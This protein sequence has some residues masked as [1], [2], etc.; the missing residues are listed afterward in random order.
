MYCNI[1]AVFLFGAPLPRG[2]VGVMGF[3]STTFV[4]VFLAIYFSSVALF[5]TA[6]IIFLRRQQPAVALVDHGRAY[7]RQW[8]THATFRIFRALIL[9][10]CVARLWLPDI[11]RWIQLMALDPALRGLG[12]LGLLGGFALAL[13]GHRTLGGQ[14]RSGV[15]ADQHT[16][17]IT[18]GIY[19]YSRNPMF[20]GVRIALVGFLLALPSLLSL[21]SLV[22]GWWMLGLQ[23]TVEEAH[24]E[25]L[26]GK[27]YRAYQQH[28]AKWWSL[29]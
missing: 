15:H 4:D 26:H 8:W 18:Q 14:W 24:L 9:C 19:A 25:R 21:V 23:T 1:L 12:V 10:V 20:I 17:L 28:V 3:V 22:T 27:R 2:E 6:R 13:V 29:R 7:Q 11:D 5:Y 16:T